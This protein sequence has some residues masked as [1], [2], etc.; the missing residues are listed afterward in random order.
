MHS[1]SLTL[2]PSVELVA[3]HTFNFDSFSSSQATIYHILIV[4]SLIIIYLINVVPTAVNNYILS[5]VICR[6]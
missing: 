1:S 6:K 5:Y 2:R 3:Y 4:V